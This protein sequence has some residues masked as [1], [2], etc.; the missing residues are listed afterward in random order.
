[1]QSYLSLTT[2]KPVLRV[3]SVITTYSLWALYGQKLKISDVLMSVNY[4]SFPYLSSSLSPQR[5]DDYTHMRDEKTESRDRS[6]V[7]AHSRFTFSNQ[8]SHFP[9]PACKSHEDW[10]VCCR[11]AR[12]PK[13]LVGRTVYKSYQY[14]LPS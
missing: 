9:E 3:S 1:M 5:A 10:S 12:V 4:N 6:N 2:Q 11:R 8:S 7:L 14:R 13:R